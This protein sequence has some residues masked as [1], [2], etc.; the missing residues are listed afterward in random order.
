MLSLLNHYN[1]ETKILKI[2]FDYNKNLDFD[3]NVDLSFSDVLIIIFT[4][5]FYYKSQFNQSVD[6][7]PK[8]LTHLTFGFYFNQTVDNLP[9]KLTHLTFGRQ[10][11]VRLAHPKIMN[12]FII[13]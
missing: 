13:V 5:N 7:L 2:P 10:T 4:D 11:P 6:N 3:K 9:K 1:K 8:N 12:I